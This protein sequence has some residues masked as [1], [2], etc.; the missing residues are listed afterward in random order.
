MGTKRNKRAKKLIKSLMYGIII[1][2]FLWVIYQNL[3]DFQTLASTIQRV[4]P[5][6][7]LNTILLGLGNFVIYSFIFQK[8]FQTISEETKYPKLL[9][10]TIVYHFL[11]ISNPLG[12]TGGSAYLVKYAV[13]RGLSHIKAVF[14]LLVT[15]LSTNLAYL[16]ILIFTLYSLNL[17]NRLELYQ[18]YAAFVIFAI[19][20]GI[21]LALAFFIILPKFSGN[22]AHTVARIINRI[23]KPV[24]GRELLSD[25]TIEDYTNEARTLSSR[26]DKS[27]YKF[28]QSLP[29]SLAYHGI[30][31]LILFLSFYAFD[32]L[33]PISK[34]MTLYG[35][36]TLFTVVSPT[37]QGLGIVEGLA[38]TAAVSVQIPG[39]GAILAILIYRLA[40]LWI[41]ALLGLLLFRY[42]HTE[43]VVNVQKAA[44]SS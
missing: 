39:S 44:P 5:F 41:P 1:I 25:R 28:L 6:L 21:I 40:V 2:F 13:E 9:T 18:W 31:V 37:P 35:V 34:I 14:G 8:S 3:E 7:L 38:Q 23:V 26:F 43:K 10:K 22:V 15:N 16:S 27:I 30:N 11:S 36:I 32:I 4:K 24:I 19:I 20:L 17:S 12:V 33:I 42:A 29:I